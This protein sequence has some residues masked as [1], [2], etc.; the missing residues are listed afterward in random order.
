[1]AGLISNILV[2]IDGSEESITAAEYAICIAAETRASLH[3]LYVV[4]TRALQDLLR[5]RIFIQSEQE[6]YARDLEEDA[7]R[8]LN[9]VEQLA[10]AK[11]MALTRRKVS[12]SINTEIKKAV[13]ELDIDLLVVGAL[14]RI[15]SR[16]D[17]IYNEAERAI[18]S[19]DCS[20]LIAK[21][22][23][24]IWSIYEAL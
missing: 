7:E 14:P 5:A 23:D 17:E 13:R 24:H 8:Y 6:E 22:E 16:R 2:Y 20:V 1:M 18:R 4:N 12:G 15:Q 3:A 21:D 11:G 10:S 19:V 9:H